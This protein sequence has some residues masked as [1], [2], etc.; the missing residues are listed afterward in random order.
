MLEDRII[1]VDAEALVLD[2]PAGL[3][4]HPGPSTPRSLEDHLDALRL[5]FARLPTPVHRL[6]RDTS[7][8]LLLA[9]NPRAHRKLSAAFEGGGVAKTYWAVLDGDVRDDQGMIDL[10]LA[11]TSS[12]ESGWRMIVSDKGRVAQTGWRVLAR[13]NGR[14][15]VEFR[16]LTGRTHQIRVHALAGLGVPIAGDPVYGKGG[17]R[18]AMLL[19]A[20]RLFIEREGQRRPIDVTAPLGDRF[21]AAGFSEADGGAPCP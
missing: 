21:A 3:A 11:K 7:G 15:M 16:P 14:T 4:V 10:P 6:D 1:F 20:R 8:C 12:R 9:R 13:R 18:D 2:K 17:A 19:H 5:G